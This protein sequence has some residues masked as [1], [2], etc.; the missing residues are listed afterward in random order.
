MQLNK[1]YLKNKFNVTLY[2][3]VI[4]LFYFYCVYLRLY[5]LFACPQVCKKGSPADS[6]FCENSFTFRVIHSYIALRTNVIVKSPKIQLT[7]HPCTFVREVKSPGTMD[8]Q[9]P[10][11][12]H[13]K[14]I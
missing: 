6:L 8:D 13:V 7:L 2:S 5:F 1:I 9:R 11:Y 12:L 14:G 10:V 4:P 3:S